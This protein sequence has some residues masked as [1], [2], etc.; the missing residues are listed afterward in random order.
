VDAMQKR[1]EL[2][3]PADVPLCGVVANFYKTKGL[4]YFIDAAAIVAKK[5]PEVRFII[6]GEGKLRP[7]LEKQIKNL[8]LQNKITLTGFREDALEIL[9]T[10]DIFVL[11]SLKEGLPFSLLEAGALGKPI[12]ATRVGGVPE[13]IDHNQ[14]GLLVPPAEA[15]T[16]A[17][18]IITLLQNKK[19][20]ET[21]G[22]KIKEKVFR[23]FD[24]ARTLERTAEVYPVRSPREKILE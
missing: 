9:A 20:V 23:D 22:Q 4:E 24:L 2:G 21:F 8:G 11:S 15:K 5:I 18:A 19:M 12:V 6:V 1:Q 13:I 16:L 7:K 3:V 17:E 14:N 10:M